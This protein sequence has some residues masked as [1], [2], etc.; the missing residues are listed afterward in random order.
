MILRRIL[1]TLALVAS[2]T[3]AI[4]TERGYFGIAIDIDGD[5]FFNP[6][7]KTVE[8]SKVAESSPAANAG[9]VVGDFIVEVEGQTVAGLKAN[10]LKAFMQRNVGEATHFVLK[11]ASG[12]TVAVVLVAAPR[13]E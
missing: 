7:L 6:V 3:T 10:D 1:M 9:V 5:G 12:A 13:A 8:V 2:A 4:A 11:R